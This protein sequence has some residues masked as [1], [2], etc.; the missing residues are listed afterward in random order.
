MLHFCV[1]G[2]IW[3]PWGRMSIGVTTESSRNS[4]PA[5]LPP[6]KNHCNSGKTRA[7]G[8]SMASIRP[9]VVIGCLPILSGCM[10]AQ[11]HNRMAGALDQYIG[12]SVASYVADRGEPTSS[13][14]LGDHESAFRWV[15]TGQGA[16]AIVPIGTALVAV[17]P[18]QIVCSVSLTASTTAAVPEYKDWIITS[19]KWEG[20]C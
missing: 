7:A 13:V 8:A 9:A 12:Q 18:R 3:E 6:D 1:R 11:Q 14:K 2:S 10:T 5:S 4:S 19:Y 16:G 20:A 17:P 15:I